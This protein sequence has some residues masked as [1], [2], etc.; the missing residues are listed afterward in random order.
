[1]LAEL[2]ARARGV[3]VAE[4]DELQP[5]N[6]LI[7]LAEN[8]LAGAKVRVAGFNPDRAEH[9]AGQPPLGLGSAPGVNQAPKTV[10]P[11]VAGVFGFGEI[12]GVVVGGPDGAANDPVGMVNVTPPAWVLQS[13]RPFAL[14]FRRCLS[15]HGQERVDHTL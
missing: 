3:E 6:L 13:L 14:L 5:V 11:G 15:Q 9:V 1:M 2:I 4:R 8:G 7:P 12:E 10:M